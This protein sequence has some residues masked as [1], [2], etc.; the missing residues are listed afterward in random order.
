LISSELLHINRG[1]RVIR[2][3]AVNSLLICSAL[4][5]LPTPGAAQT[6]CVVPPDS[7]WRPVN[8]GFELQTRVRIDS[9][10]LSDRSYPI[11]RRVSP[12]S[13]A[14]SAG[15]RDGDILLA[16]NGFDVLTRRDSA[17]TK[18]PG[19]PTRLAI[20]RGDSTFERTVVGVPMPGC[21]SAGRSRLLLNAN[22]SR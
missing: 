21:K 14:D 17:R 5:M 11:L 1:E 4:T 10:R 19:V 18:G 12:N 22:G 13:A 9:G 8:F 7:S 20:R 6:F 2:R 3:L 15:L 16:V